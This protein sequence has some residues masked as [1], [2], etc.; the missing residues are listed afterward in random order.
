MICFASALVK[1]SIP[2]DTKP[3]TAV[4]FKIAKSYA[5]SRVLV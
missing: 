4:Y 2:G 3:D 5:A 1:R